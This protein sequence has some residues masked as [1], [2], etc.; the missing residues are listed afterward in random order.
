MTLAFRHEA[1]CYMMSA[2]I[3]RQAFI[4]GMTASARNLLEYCFSYAGHYFR[5]SW[6]SPFIALRHFATPVSFHY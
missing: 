2:A 6:L 3:R 5:H 1:V 4:E